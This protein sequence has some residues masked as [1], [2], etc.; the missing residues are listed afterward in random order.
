MPEP[1]EIGPNRQGIVVG[2]SARERT[3]SSVNGWPLQFGLSPVLRETRP[4]PLSPHGQLIPSSS[5][6]V[7]FAP[8]SPVPSPG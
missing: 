8:S 4:F 3:G 1:N 7:S 5:L 6:A 2:G